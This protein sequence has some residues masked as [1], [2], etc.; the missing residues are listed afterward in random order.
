VLKYLFLL[1]LV[2]FNLKAVFFYNSYHPVSINVLH[3]STQT[4]KCLVV[5]KEKI[6]VYNKFQREIDS[7]NYI[8]RSNTLILYKIAGFKDSELFLVQ[9]GWLRYR[10][11]VDDKEHVDYKVLELQ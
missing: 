7:Y 3:C 5:T 1:L 4:A 11:S 10:L 2:P 9:N 8:R 6:V